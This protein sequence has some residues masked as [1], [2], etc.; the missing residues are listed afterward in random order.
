MNL[1]DLKEKKQREVLKLIG[2]K[3]MEVSRDGSEVDIDIIL[4][5]LQDNFL[6][7]LGNDDFFGT[8]GWEHWLGLD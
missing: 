7:P 1:T 3:F 2:E 5:Y 8:E 6:D 4:G